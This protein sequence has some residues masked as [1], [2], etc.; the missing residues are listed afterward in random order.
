M[1]LQYFNKMDV[2]II[3]KKILSSDLSELLSWETIYL[4]N[5]IKVINYNNSENNIVCMIYYNN[6]FHSCNLDTKTF[7]LHS[8]GVDFGTKIESIKLRSNNLYSY[9]ENLSRYLN[10]VNEQHDNYIF[11]KEKSRIIKKTDEFIWNPYLNLHIPD[12]YNF[13][14]NE[15]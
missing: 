12:N 8:D 5:D 9:L 2:D 6:M 13:N 7:H 3:Q 11:R 14:S 4:N 1:E 15:L 10:D